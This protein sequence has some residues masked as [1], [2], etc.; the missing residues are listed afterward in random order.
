[1]RPSAARLRWIAAA[2]LLAVAGGTATAQT[3]R[4]LSA[5]PAS[6]AT[7]ASPHGDIDLTCETCH[8]ADGWRPLRPDPAFDHARDTGQPLEASHARATCAGCHLGLQFTGLEN[9]GTDCGTCHLDVH[10]GALGETCQSCHEPTDWALVAGVEVHAST[11]FPLTGAHLGVS[12]ETCHA[13]GAQAA[14]FTPLP[15]ECVACHV[16]DRAATESGPVPHLANAFPDDCAA[17]HHTTAWSGGPFEH[18]VASGGFSLVGAHI[19][20]DCAACH[21]TPGFAS[22]FDAAGPD[23]CVSCHAQDADAAR[24]DHAAFPETCTTCHTVERWDGASG[25]HVVLSGGFGL[26]GAHLDLDCSACHAADL[27]PIWDPASQDD[28]VTCH[29]ADADAATPDHQSFPETCGTCHATTGW[30]GASIDHPALSGGFSLLGAHTALD[31]ATCH[32]EPDFALPWSPASDADCVGCHAADADDADPDH[33]DFPETCTACHGLDTWTGATVDHPTLSGGFNLAG[34]HAALDCATCHSE[35][36]FEVPWTPAS[37]AD[38]VSCHAEDADDA[39][40]NHDDFPTTCTTCHTPDDWEGA[41]VDHP[42][43]A[44]GFEL[45]GA[46]LAAECNAC[47]S[48]PDFEVPWTPAGQGDCVACHAADYASTAGGFVDHVAGGLP[49]ECA[50]CHGVD[51]WAGATFDH[52]SEADGFELVGAHLTLACATCHSGPDGEVPWDPDTDQDCVSCHAADA[53]GA[54][55][56]HDTFPDT[57]TTCHTPDAWE[58]ATGDHVVLSDGFALLGAHLSL[59]CETC[60]SGPDG[61]LP[62]T[63][64]SDQDCASCHTDDVPAAPDHSYFPE[65]CATCHGPDA[66]PGAVVDHPA[67]SGGFALVGAHLALDCGTC[68][69]GPDGELLWSPDSNADCVSCHAQ[70]AAG[71]TP[72]HDPFP[73][74]CTACHGTDTWMGATVDH[75]ELSGGFALVGTH[76]TL[77]C[78]AC[79]AGPDGEVPWDPASDADCVSCHASDAD[80]AALPHDTFPQT[81]TTCHGTDTWPSTSVDHPSVSGGFDLV[82]AHLAL[83]CAACHSEAD[84]SPPWTPASDTDCVSCHADDAANAEPPHTGFPTTCLECHTTDRWQGATFDH[85][86]FPIYSGRHEGEWATCQTCHIEPSDFRVFSCVTCHEHNRAEMDDKHDRVGG[87]VYESTAC[88]SCHPD[89]EE[90]FGQRFERRLR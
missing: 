51:T 15:T 90:D 10:A 49:S 81:C 3:E 12:C 4:P 25:D 63:P 45:L 40:P 46:H 35:P 29:A 74:T 86:A 41:T 5:H 58:G 14:A 26:V 31:C 61:E 48:G 87:Y 56:P 66:W 83:D 42:A 65:T 7:S 82:G 13:D 80:G 34:A 76:L 85:D 28:C 8:T 30:P 60:H 19:T 2:L 6:L 22:R 38:C 16:D 32:S 43:L 23:D 27:A 21:T 69:S 62:W 75:P 17:C 52:A 44:D 1:M 18:S 20:V 53:A 11:A 24:V 71:A 67:L 57:C 70:D 50:S 72:T 37:D 55:P 33:D 54:Q 47:H 9:A 84:G 36:G 77:D 68:H 39:D 64:D 78:D 73:E 88:Y 59:A 89:G 79:H